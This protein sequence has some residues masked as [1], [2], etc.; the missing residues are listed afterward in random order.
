MLHGLFIF[1]QVLFQQ[2]TK[3]QCNNL[4]SSEVSILNRQDFILFRM[5]ILFYEGAVVRAGWERSETLGY[6]GSQFVVYMTQTCFLLSQSQT[7]ISKPH[8][9]DHACFKVLLRY[10]CIFS[11]YFNQQKAKRSERRELLSTFESFSETCKFKN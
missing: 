11:S 8:I 10:I 2:K 3:G 5:L 7:P 4:R 1:T 6:I 9:P